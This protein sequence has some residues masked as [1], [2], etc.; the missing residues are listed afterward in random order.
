MS[1]YYAGAGVALYLGDCREVLPL[2]DLDDVDAVVADPPY[3][4]TA[5]SWDRWP[6]GWVEA[7]AAA[8]PARA[9][10]WCF[11]STRMFLDRRDDFAAWTFAQDVVWE[12]HNGSSSA[13]DRFRRVHE[14][15][16]HWYRGPWS[17]VYKR[18]VTTPDATARRLHRKER[19]AQW[20][21]IGAAKYMTEEG[22]PR[23]A[24]SVLYVRS[25]HGYAVHPT[26]KP[27]GILHPLL[28]YS[29]RPGGLVLDPMAGSGSTLR[30]AM[31]AGQRA[32]GIEVDEEACEAAA[33]RL[34]QGSLALW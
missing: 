8:V 7:V 34:S 17:E 31:D 4:E 14:N 20:G 27:L 2:L 18:P 19:P 22:G 9:S 15:V 25:C 26:Q 3:G 6:E 12:K 33:T 13:A 28:S 5:L 32:V 23:L 10:L 24:R 16:L 1:P 29:V 21:D 11:G 30:A